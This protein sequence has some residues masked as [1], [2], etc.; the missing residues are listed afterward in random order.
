MLPAVLRYGYIKITPVMKGSEN[1]PEEEYGLEILLEGFG[2]GTVFDEAD[3]SEEG[4][5]P[6]D[7]DAVCEPG[8]SGKE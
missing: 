5:G 1:M 8:G 3:F 6:L 4:L 2:D 7:P